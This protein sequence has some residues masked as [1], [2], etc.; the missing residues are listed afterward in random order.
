MYKL[1]S[2]PLLAK[3]SNE[4]TA[5]VERFKQTANMNLLLPLLHLDSS[6][7]NI[8][9]F[10]NSH[11]EEVCA[12]E[13]S[14]VLIEALTERLT[15]LLSQTW[16]L[17]R[18]SKLPDPKVAIRVMIVLLG[19][20]PL[21]INYYSGVLDWVVG[22]LGL[23]LPGTTEFTRSPSEGMLSRFMKDLECSIKPDDSGKSMGWSIQEGTPH[24]AHAS[25]PWPR[26]RLDH[27]QLIEQFKEMRVEGRKTLFSTLVDCA[28][29]FLT[30]EDRDQMANLI[31]PDPAPLPLVTSTTAPVVTTI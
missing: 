14:K 31:R 29:G 17:V 27:K 9:R 22:R 4:I 10:I 8:D 3:H 21:G 28:K 16:R 18:S 24:W 7:S 1:G 30:V 19:T 12:K 13:E 26:G 11:L 5:A 15:N 23:T 2:H 25:P 6:R 20:Q